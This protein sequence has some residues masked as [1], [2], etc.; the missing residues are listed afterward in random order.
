MADTCLAQA[1]GRT[2]R[3]D[4]PHVDRLEVEQL[5]TMYY[6]LCNMYYVLYAMCYVLCAM[7]TMFWSI[8]FLKFPRTAASADMHQPSMRPIALRLPPPGR[9]IS[10]GASTNLAAEGT[11]RTYTLRILSM[12]A[13]EIS[14]CV[15]NPLRLRSPV[16]PPKAL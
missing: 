8:L 9:T 1:G 13:F 14:L 6:V 2:S 11:A 7:Y 12:R 15:F 3:V 5:C 10:H 4:V 16:G